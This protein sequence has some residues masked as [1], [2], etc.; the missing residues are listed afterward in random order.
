[1]N[2]DKIRSVEHSVLQRYKR[3]KKLFEK[4]IIPEQFLYDLP[5]STELEI[6]ELQRIAKDL[7]QKIPESRTITV[8][9]IFKDKQG[10][11]HKGDIKVKIFTDGT[12]YPTIIK[13]KS[14]NFDRVEIEFSDIEE[15]FRKL[16]EKYKSS[17][18]KYSKAKMLVI[19]FKIAIKIRLYLIEKYGSEEA[20]RIIKDAEYVFDHNK[21]QAI[22]YLLDNNYKDVSHFGI[23]ETFQNENG[24]FFKYSRIDFINKKIELIVKNIGE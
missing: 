21:N 12:F 4:T 24:E 9:K 22:C 6:K 23:Y 2:E 11:E 19:N 1:M 13:R 10:N 3:G 14:K 8:S 5:Y 15:E 20:E 18:T 7:F 17:K 16:E